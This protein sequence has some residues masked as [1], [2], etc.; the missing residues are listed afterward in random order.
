MVSPTRVPESSIS[1]ALSAY[2]ILTFA[3]EALLPIYADVW[4]LKGENL[5]ED[6]RGR[7]GVGRRMIFL[8]VDRRRVFNRE[9]HLD[10]LYALMKKRASADA[11]ISLV[12]NPR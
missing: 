2:S 12:T 9:Q 8:N 11:A 1:W 5:S 3:N 7:S 10:S 4:G 6:L